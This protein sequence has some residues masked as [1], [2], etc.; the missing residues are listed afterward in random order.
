MMRDFFAKFP[1][2][3]VGRVH[4]F[5]RTVRIAPVPVLGGSRSCASFKSF[6]LLRYEAN[7][8]ER[9]IEIVRIPT[10]EVRNVER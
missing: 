4:G 5:T 9:G 7:S 1:M 6:R 10:G 2:R 8:S 3:Y